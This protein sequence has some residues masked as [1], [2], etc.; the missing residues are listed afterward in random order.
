MLFVALLV[1]FANQPAASQSQTVGVGDR[2]RLTIAG[3][4]E[5]VVVDLLALTA[6][7]VWFLAGT[8]KYERTAVSRQEITR[9]EV[10]DV[11]DVNKRTAVGVVVGGVLAGGLWLGYLRSSTCDGPCGAGVIFTPVVALGGGVLGALTG[12]L[13]ARDHW[14]TAMLA[15]Q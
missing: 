4:A 7:S 14:T 8:Q 13:S 15:A 6:D 12:R 9:V 10:H 3:R 11:A 2:V 5:P 1:M